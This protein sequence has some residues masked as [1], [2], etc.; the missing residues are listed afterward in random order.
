LYGSSASGIN[1]ILA[2]GGG[3]TALATFVVPSL[4]FDDLTITKR[5]DELPKPPFSIPPGAPR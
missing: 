5:T 4:L 3:G 1:A 2:S